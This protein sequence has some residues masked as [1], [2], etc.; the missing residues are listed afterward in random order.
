MG[1]KYDD[2]SKAARAETTSKNRYEAE[3]VG[4]DE[5]AISQARDDYRNNAG[6]ANELYKEFSDDPTG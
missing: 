3:L 1:K 5:A 2:Y 6:I 4:G